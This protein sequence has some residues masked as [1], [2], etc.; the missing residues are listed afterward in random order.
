MLRSVQACR[1]AS[2][3]E[4]FCSCFN[5]MFQT[6]SN[7]C[8]CMYVCMYVVVCVCKYVVVCLCMYVVVFVCMYVCMCVCTYVCTYVMY[9]GMYVMYVCNTFTEI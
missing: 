4:M 6:L 8:M 5:A 2:H 7:K 3:L 9:V 1:L